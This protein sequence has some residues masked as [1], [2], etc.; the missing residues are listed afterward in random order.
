MKRTAALVGATG[1]AGTT[2]L[3][4]ELGAMLAH[5]GRDVAIL[6]AAFATQGL[7]RHVP[8]RIGNDLTALLT[9]GKIE[10]DEGELNEALIDGARTRV[11][12][13]PSVF[14]ETPPILC[15][16]RRYRVRSLCDPSRG[17]QCVSFGHLHYSGLDKS[18]NLC[19]RC[20]I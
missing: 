17:I 8:G 9:D 14:A 7:A 10:F 5:A 13:S 6:D 1:G 3:C 2:R 12:D 11:L 15:C 20:R 19:R 18:L 4:I 16:L